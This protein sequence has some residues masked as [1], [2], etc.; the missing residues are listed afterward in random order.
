MSQAA[1]SLPESSCSPFVGRCDLCV[2]TQN[3]LR[4]RRN[5]LRHGQ[6]RIQIGQ[7]RLRGLENRSG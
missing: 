7:N 5:Q 2:R 6:N 3:P 4:D 1:K